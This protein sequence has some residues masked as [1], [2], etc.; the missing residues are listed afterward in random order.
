MTDTRPTLV[1]Q[2][3]PNCRRR[4]FD[5]AAVGVVR[6]TCHRCRERVQIELK[7]VKIELKTE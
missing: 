4:L 2:R 5:A 3:C 1:E 7:V 6:L